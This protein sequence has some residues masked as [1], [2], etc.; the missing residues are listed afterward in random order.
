M[1]QRYNS[2]EPLNNGIVLLMFYTL[3]QEKKQAILSISKSNMQVNLGKVFY[4]DNEN[5]LFSNIQWEGGQK[6]HNFIR[7]KFLCY[8]YI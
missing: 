1:R 5:K 7:L 3:M 4:I 6:Y 8:H 2:G